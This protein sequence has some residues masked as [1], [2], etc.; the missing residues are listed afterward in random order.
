[1]VGAIGFELEALC[2]PIRRVASD[3]AQGKL[4]TEPAAEI[5]AFTRR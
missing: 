3:T 1:M 4:R 5:E 2:G